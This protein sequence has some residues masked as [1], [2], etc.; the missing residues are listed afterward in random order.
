MR[1]PISAGLMID[2]NPNQYRKIF[3]ILKMKA[4]RIK[5]LKRDYYE[6]S[7]LKIY[8]VHSKNI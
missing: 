4:Y 6:I 7:E 1:K 3:S 2:G 8:L 5:F